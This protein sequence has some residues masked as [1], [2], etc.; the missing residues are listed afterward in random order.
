MVEPGGLCLPL[1]Q[2]R[3]K[4]FQMKALPVIRRKPVFS[5]GF[6]VFFR[7]ITHVFRP[8]VLRVFPVDLPHEFV[9]VCL[10]KDR[11]GSQFHFMIGQ[12]F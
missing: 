9:P 7:G 3:F 2:D 6:D 1:K 10:C 11:G 8:A 12:Q 5:Y 4:G